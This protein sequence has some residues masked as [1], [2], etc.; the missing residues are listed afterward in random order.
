LVF[1][2]I[3]YNFVEIKLADS[4]YLE[5]FFTLSFLILILYSSLGILNNYYQNRYE[6]S[7]LVSQAFNYQNLETFD[8]K[9]NNKTCHILSIQATIEELC[10][11]NNH[12]N[13]TKIVVIGDSHSRTFLKPFNDVFGNDY[14]IT[15]ATGSSCIFFTNTTNTFCKRSDQEKV[16][17]LL[18]NSENSIII[19]F[20]DL[21]DKI[22]NEENNFIFNVPLT[23]QQLAKKNKVIVINQIPLFPV[24]VMNK[25]LS[26]Q[27]LGI[28]NEISYPREEWLSN[29]KRIQVEEMYKSIDSKN[30]FLIDTFEIFCNEIKLNYCVGATQDRIYI[31][32]DNHPSTEGSK[33][34]ISKIELIL[35]NLNFIK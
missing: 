34:I 16:I 25:I 3:Q 6:N 31:Y 20:A 1:G 14:S 27:L 15:Y 28:V 30:I 9:I 26:N 7:E 13:L 5:K 24:N 29:K 17:S 8:L 35:N 32:D 33:L 21:Q 18:N 10:V 19:Y 22:N 23:I 11:S 4:D 12:K 2:I